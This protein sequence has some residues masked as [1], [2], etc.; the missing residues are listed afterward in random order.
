MQTTEITIFQEVV[1]TLIL[2]IIS[3]H[4]GRKSTLPGKLF[5][6]IYSKRWLD[7]ET[8]AEGVSQLGRV[9][10]TRPPNI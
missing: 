10:H 8:S 6:K 2:F 3:V 4:F 7:T 5:D 1:L 9:E